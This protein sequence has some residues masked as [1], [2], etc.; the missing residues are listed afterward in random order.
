[1][2]LAEVLADPVAVLTGSGWEEPAVGAVAGE[3][4]TLQ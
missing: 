3:P 1:M 4:Q 2:R